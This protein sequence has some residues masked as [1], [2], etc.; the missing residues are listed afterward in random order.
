MKN[1]LEFSGF[2]TLTVDMKEFLSHQLDSL[3]PE[4]VL[5]QL[6]IVDHTGT[7]LFQS[8]HPEMV[9]RN[10]HQKD[11]SC[12]RCHLRLGAAADAA[13]RLLRTRVQ[14]QGI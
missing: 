3:D 9:V 7:L 1:V 11:G 14:R 5:N 6:W 4:I 2:L 8:R 12:D 10:I 13:D